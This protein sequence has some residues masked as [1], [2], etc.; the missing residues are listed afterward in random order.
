M[1]IK[2]LKLIIL[3]ILF[4]STLGCA[5]YKVVKMGEINKSQKT[6]T[7]PYVG[8][9]ISEIKIALIKDGWKLKS[10]SEGIV[11]EGVNNENIKTQTKTFYKTRYRMTI[12]ESVRMSQW[13]L[14]TYISIVDN[15]TNEE[16]MLITGDSNGA[17]G[18]SPSTTASRLISALREIEM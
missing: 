14:K 5:S 12:H 16:I 6:M 9:S 10:S 1:K 17:G 15:T 13:V 3:A 4:A 2:V 18:V 11:T 7:I 8:F